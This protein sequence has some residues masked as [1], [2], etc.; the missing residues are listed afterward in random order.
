MLRL[1]K[2]YLI[3][4]I[5]LTAVVQLRRC[6]PTTLNDL[7]NDLV[8]YDKVCTGSCATM[9]ELLNVAHE[10]DWQTIMPFALYS[11]TLGAE[12]V[13]SGAQGEDG[14]V[15]V[16]LP[17]LQK[18][19]IVGRE[20]LQLKQ[21][22]GI[23]G[24]AKSLDDSKATFKCNRAKNQCLVSLLGQ[25]IAVAPFFDPWQPSWEA[26][27]CSACIRYRKIIHKSS[28]EALWKD[29]PAIWNL[30]PWGQLSGGEQA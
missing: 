6:F 23:Y 10:T 7:N 25:S 28:R 4:N 8:L 20:R 13:F 5:R 3:E 29:L 26:V 22:D 18:R 14:M 1:G 2:K 16:L 30:P 24:W 12:E 9:V 11:C 17:D 19:L 27:L 21:M 15:V